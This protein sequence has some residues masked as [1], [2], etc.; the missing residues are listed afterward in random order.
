MTDNKINQVSLKREKVGLF[1][2][3]R[4]EL[5][6]LINSSFPKEA[7]VSLVSLCSLALKRGGNFS[8]F[9]DGDDFAGFS[10]TMSH[11]SCVFIL[12]LA[13]SEKSRSKGYGSSILNKIKEDYPDKSVLLNIEYPFEMAIN[14]EQRVRRLEFYKRNG[15]C[16]TGY[17]L[18]NDGVSYMILS[19]KEEFD[20]KAYEGIFEK[21]SMKRYEFCIEEAKLNEEGHKI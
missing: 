19:S 2:K 8:A 15:F 6:H 4:Q 21:L 17:I 16:D 18:R 7:Q 11:D 10:F 12:Y 13:V 1:F 20:K 5:E 3:D 14:Y 9:Y